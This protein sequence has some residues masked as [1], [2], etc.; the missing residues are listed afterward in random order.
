[1]STMKVL[2]AS[3]FSCC[4]VFALAPGETFGASP[5]G[6]GAGAASMHL[7]VHPSVGQS[8]QH[9]RGRDTGAFWLPGWGYYYGSA[10]AN[11]Q[12]DVAPI[13]PNEALYTCTLDIPWDWAHRCPS[14]PA[15]PPAPIVIM[16]SAPGCPAQ[17]ATVPLGDGKEQTVTI[18]RC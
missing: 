10:P 13:V 11:S 7:N 12:P 15:P 2:A 4:V 14:P 6:H 17:S 8:R 18:V 3:F 16:P 1:M 9:R 5:G